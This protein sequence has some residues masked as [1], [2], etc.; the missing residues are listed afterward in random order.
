MGDN[1]GQQS[2]TSLLGELQEVGNALRPLLR[3]LPRA[4]KV[5]D[6]LTGGVTNAG[7]EAL[8]SR[9]NRYRTGNLIQEA[10]DV[11]DTTGLPLPDVFDRLVRQ[12]RIDELTMEALRRVSE[13]ANSQ[14]EAKSAN[15]TESGKPQTTTDRWFQELYAEAG[16]VDEENVREAFVRIL[17]GEMQAPG[18]FSLRSLRVMGAIS[19]STA[20]HFRRAASVSIRLTSNGKHIIDARIPEVGGQLGQNCLQGDGL[21]YDVLTDL[22]ENGLVHSDYSSFHP[23]GPRVL[24][25]DAQQPSQS[26][27]HIPF[28]YQNATWLLIPENNLGNVQPLKV[29]GAKLTSCGVELLKIVDIESLPNFTEKLV[30]H[31]LRSG[32]KMTRSTK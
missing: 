18:S 32:Y 6:K 15:T 19:Q 3:R 29:R 28:T 24:V 13:N 14:S 31:F 12:R 9:L 4:K 20:E 5:I 22:T 1:E 11:A 21:S 17:V 30:R 8:V 23:Y 27:M 25:F 26:V 7:F 10:Q 16:A 2:Q